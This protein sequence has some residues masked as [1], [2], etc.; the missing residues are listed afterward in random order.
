MTA[1]TVLVARPLPGM[2]YT[3]A[4]IATMMATLRAAFMASPRLVAV[5]RP[6]CAALRRERPQRI[7]H[8][9]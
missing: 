2:K 5:A 7:S 1:S 8:P 6:G 9:R 4:A 3:P